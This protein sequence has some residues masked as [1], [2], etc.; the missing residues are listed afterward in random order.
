MQITAMTYEQS[1]LQYFLNLKAHHERKLE[2]WQRIQA[3]DQR[4]KWKKED[5]CSYHGAAVQY[6]ED[7]IKALE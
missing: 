7:A 5:M 3:W 2:Y 4:Q 6:C 1:R